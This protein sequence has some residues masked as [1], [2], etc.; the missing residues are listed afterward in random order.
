MANPGLGD[1]VDDHVVC[2]VEYNGA[3]VPYVSDLVLSHPKLDLHC[4]SKV[5]SPP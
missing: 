2:A 5:G 4:V 1:T 3:V